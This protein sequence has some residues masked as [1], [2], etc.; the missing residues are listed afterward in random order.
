MV[1]AK[2]ATCNAH[3]WERNLEV[4]NKLERVVRVCVVCGKKEICWSQPDPRRKAHI[5]AQGGRDLAAPFIA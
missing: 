4:Q 2:P 1:A 3:T 5:E